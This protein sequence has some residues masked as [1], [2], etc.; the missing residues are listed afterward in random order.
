MQVVSIANCASSNGER[1]SVMCGAR[2]FDTADAQA[3]D[4]AVQVGRRDETTRAPKIRISYAQHTNAQ[5]LESNRWFGRIGESRR[6]PARRGGGNAAGGV[7]AT[8]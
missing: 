7:M 1:G 8:A 6:D 4:W 5:S 2:L 3:E